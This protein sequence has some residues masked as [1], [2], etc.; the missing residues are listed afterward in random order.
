MS[1]GTAGWITVL[2]RLPVF[3]N[4]DAA[5]YRAPVEDE[6]FLDTARFLSSATTPRG[7]SGGIRALS[8]ETCWH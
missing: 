3:Y 4:P 8:T 2:F 6:K 5:G 7:G 1:N